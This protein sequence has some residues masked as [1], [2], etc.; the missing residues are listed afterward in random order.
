MFRKNAKVEIEKIEKGE[1]EN[2]KD[3]DSDEDMP[4]LISRSKWHG[5]CDSDEDEENENDEDKIPDLIP[6]GK[7]ANEDVDSDDESIPELFEPQGFEQV[8]VVDET[9][10]TEDQKEKF[11]LDSG[12]S[13][14]IVK[15]DEK[16]TDIK[17]SNKKVRVGNE[18]QVTAK[19][20]GNLYVLESGSD[21]SVKMQVAH[22]PDFAKNVIS[23]PK[24]IDAGCNITFNETHAL[25]TNKEGKVVMRCERDPIDRIYYF[26]GTRISKKPIDQVLQT[27]IGKTQTLKLTKWARRKR[28]KLN[29]S[30]K[31]WISTKRTTKWVTREQPYLRP[32]VN[33]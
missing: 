8:F 18:A 14:T 30:P 5:V 23:G 25:V 20:E 27:K 21:R 12:A 13:L 17:A 26:V 9:N 10:E 7:D 16:M 32:L 33:T 24:L 31:Q 19:S 28:R 29:R 3:Y 15:S 6:K 11:L 1:P 4:E 22:C 2:N